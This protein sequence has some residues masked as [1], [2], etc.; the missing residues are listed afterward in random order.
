MA[1]VLIDED[2]LIRLAG[3]CYQVRALFDVLEDEVEHEERAYQLATIG[4]AL[5]FELAV[6]VE[7]LYNDES[8]NNGQA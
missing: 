8:T 3:Q 2:V 7:A 1:K 5:A 4:R 6:E